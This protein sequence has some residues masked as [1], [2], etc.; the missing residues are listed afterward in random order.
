MK[1]AA[2][3][4]FPSLHTAHTTV[5]LAFVRR[6][7]PR[8]SFLYLPIALGLYVSTLYLRMHYAIDVA[9][10]FATGALAVFTGPRLE[11]WWYESGGATG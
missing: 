5:V 4:C 8:L 1:G 2:R 10:G 9:A 11:R 7:S 6:F 3:D